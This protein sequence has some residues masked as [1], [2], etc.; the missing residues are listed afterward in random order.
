MS[1]QSWP[2]HIRKR[3]GRDLVAKFEDRE[4]GKTELY[5][6]NRQGYGMAMI[7]G[8]SIEPVTT[9]EKSINPTIA[10]LFKSRHKFR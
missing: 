7:A 1:Q 2:F 9:D 8:S 4:R 5:G 6:H 10:A 3:L